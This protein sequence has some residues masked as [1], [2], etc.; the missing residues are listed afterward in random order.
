[1]PASKAC[2]KPMIGIPLWVQRDAV[3][4]VV[5]NH[6]YVRAV[7][8]NGGIPLL[9]SPMAARSLPAQLSL[10][11]ALLLPGGFDVNPSL[12]LEQKLPECEQLREDIDNE[13]Y[14][15]LSEAVKRRLPILGICRGM[16]Y[17]NIYFGGSLYQDM[18]YQE[19][20]TEQHVLTH[21]QKCARK[22]A[23][24]KIRVLEGSLL[25]SWLL[26]AGEHSVNS[27]HHQAVKQPGNHLEVSALAS[28]GTVEAIENKERLILG[29]QWHPEELC[30]EH[31]S[32]KALFQSFIGAASEQK[33][34]RNA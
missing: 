6:A 19:K 16:Q 22:E 10:M 33:E 23:S 12:Y 26:S 32:M 9:L 25:A 7:D 29:V 4:R 5:V 20:N 1:M 3:P 14:S 13:W 11:D 27:L 15:I 2:A 18:Q 8:Q 17:L 34:A 24:H 21:T 31:A 30:E 28:D